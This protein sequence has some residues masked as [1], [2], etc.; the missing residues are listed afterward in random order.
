MSL[1]KVFV[2]T[3][4]WM[5]MADSADPEHQAAIRYRDHWLEEGGVL[6]STDFV[7]DETLTLLRLRLGIDAAER[8]WDQVDSSTRV[9]WEWIDQERAE[10]G[11]RWFFKWRD[12]SF[13]FT[14]CTSFAVMKELR[15][16]RAITSDRHF[17]QA[18]FDIAP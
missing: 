2:D 8:W 10:K 12:K 11:R 1:K 9:I 6:L 7:L 4:G 18:G 14:D 13:S 3:A 15:V 16:Q 17:R 5:M